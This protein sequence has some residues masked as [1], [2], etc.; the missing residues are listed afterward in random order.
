MIR[1]EVQSVETES[2]KKKRPRGEVPG[3]AAVVAAQ[4]F[5][6]RRS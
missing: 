5:F 6:V 4:D 2:G 3:V 1:G